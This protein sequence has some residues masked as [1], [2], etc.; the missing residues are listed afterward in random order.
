M[1]ALSLDYPSALVALQSRG[2][3]GIHLGLSRTEAL[4]AALD[5]PE[6][7]F[8]GA[9]IAGTNG[10]GSVLALLT[11][12]LAAA[13]YRV[14]STPKPHLVTYRERAQIGGVPIS[15]ERFAEL[16]SRVLPLADR[17]AKRHGDPTEFELLYSLALARG[18]LKTREEL[19]L[20][21]AERADAR[22]GAN[23]K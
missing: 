18:R 3:F 13:G 2:R 22:A 6:R 19:L 16:A 4:L 17:V 15:P 21:V 1:S 20:E 7:T 9:L 23:R 10:K 5:H 8:R 14:G 12:A 11:S